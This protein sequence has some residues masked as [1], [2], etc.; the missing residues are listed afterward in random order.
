MADGSGILDP[1]LLTF[2]TT[3]G[4]PM[5]LEAL[6]R[7]RAVQLALAS[8]GRPFPKNVGEGL[9][10]LGEALGERRLDDQLNAAEKSYT[11]G[12]DADPAMTTLPKVSALDPAVNPATNELR[13]R[14]TAYYAGGQGGAAANPTLVAGDTSPQATP[15]SGD[16]SGGD[17]PRAAAIGAIETGGQADPYR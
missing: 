3:P 7:R 17:D 11:G 1:T 5:S 9:T 12:R 6:K 16:P 10:S 8:K 4:A 2:A 15:V 14:L 13:N